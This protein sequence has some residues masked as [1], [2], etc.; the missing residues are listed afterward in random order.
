MGLFI[1]MQ[2]NFCT[3]FVKYNRKFDYKFE[4]TKSKMQPYE[5]SKTPPIYTYDS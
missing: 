2:L 4:K 1:A 3:L 5:T